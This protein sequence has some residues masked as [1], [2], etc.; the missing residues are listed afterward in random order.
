M[1]LYKE[2]LHVLVLKKETFLEKQVCSLVYSFL[3][4]RFINCLSFV[5]FIVSVYKK[6]LTPYIIIYIKTNVPSISYLN[7]GLVLLKLC[8]RFIKKK[9]GATFNTVKKVNKNFTLLRSPF[10]DKKSREQIVFHNNSSVVTFQ[11][12]V[13]KLIIINYVEYIIKKWFFKISFLKLLIKKKL[14][15]S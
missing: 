15:F 12:G 1:L 8:S 5:F 6:N 13:N 11:I 10:V 2:F 4:K 14:I 3:R 9:L 7:T